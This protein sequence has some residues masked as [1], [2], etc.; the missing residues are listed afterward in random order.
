MAILMF[1]VVPPVSCV[2]AWCVDLLP[3]AG[4]LLLSK[5]GHFEVTPRF[6]PVTQSRTSFRNTFPSAPPAPPAPSAQNNVNFA[7]GNQVVPIIEIPGYGS[8]SAKL[9]CEKLKIKS[10]KEADKLKKAKEE[11]SGLEN[12][13]AVVL[14]PPAMFF[15]FRCLVPVNPVL[16]VCRPSCWGAAAASEGFVPS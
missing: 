16:R 7:S 12:S 14:W 9:M 11:V 3:V 4:P 6:G 2:L 15:F 13:T 8:T 5:L 1:L 10:C